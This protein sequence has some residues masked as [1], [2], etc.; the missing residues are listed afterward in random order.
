MQ[1]LQCLISM[2]KET[3]GTFAEPQPQ[4]IRPRGGLLYTK[5]TNVRL[6]S[7]FIY[8]RF[9]G[10]PTFLARAS[11]K[12]AHPHR[13]K[14]VMVEAMRTF[15]RTARGRPKYCVVGS[16]TPKPL[17]STQPPRGQAVISQPPM[18]EEKPRGELRAPEPRIHV[19]RVRTVSG[20]SV[21]V[22][23]GPSV[24]MEN[25]TALRAR[26]PFRLEPRRVDQIRLNFETNG[27]ERLCSVFTPVPACGCAIGSPRII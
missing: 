12:A 10:V 23:T 17:T 20:T 24:L 1:L 11:D 19:A 15:E 4:L 3:S 21:W 25:M 13:K 5:S 8:S 2:A 9:S 6:D 7:P 16:V 22:L 14:C 18:P 27:R 26:P